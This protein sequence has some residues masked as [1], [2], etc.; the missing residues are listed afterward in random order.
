[1]LIKWYNPPLEFTSLMESELKENF[2]MSI[3]AGFIVPHPPII[4]PEIGKGEEFKIQKTIDAYRK[5][6]LKI[7]EL[8]PDTIIVSTPHS[9]TYADYFHIS[10]GENARGDMR[11]FGAPEVKLEVGYDTAFVKALSKEVEDHQIA[12]GTLGEEDPSLDHGTFLPIYF[13]NQVYTDYQVVRLSISGFSLFTHYCLGKCIAKTSNRLNKRVVYIASGDL[14]HKLSEEGPYGYAEEGPTFDGEVVETI[15]TGNF[16]KFLQFPAAFCHCAGEC[17]LRSFVIMAGALDGKQVDAKLL[18][19]E[20]PFGVGYA[21]GSFEVVGEDES[22]HFDKLYIAFHEKELEDIKAKEDEYVKLARLSLETYILSGEKIKIPVDISE[23]LLK[24]KAGVFVSL[25]KEGLLRGCVGTF[26]STRSCIAEEIIEN[27]ILAGTQ[28]PR[29]P[30]ISKEELIELIYSVD[31]LG[32]V[33]AV[34]HM[35]DLDPIKYG[36]IVTSG[37]K[38]GLLLPNLEGIDSV[39][40]QV[41]IA[42]QKAGILSH[43]TYKLERFEVVRHQ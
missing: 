43:E 16:F 9:V 12:A 18:S 24:N 31:I 25:K 20:G 42:K 5:V 15:K 29:F 8:R 11:K 41:E 4:I 10:P 23:D 22:R 28:D 38:R 32:N 30:K 39:E 7:A 14:S 13:I 37:Y 21:V 27:A 3:V 35:T 36:V 17:G 6:A 33:E 26:E 1:M 2:F 34:Q 19:Y 40:E